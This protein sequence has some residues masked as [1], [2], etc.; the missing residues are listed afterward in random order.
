MVW[1]LGCTYLSSALPWSQAAD[2]ECGPV[3]QVV[4][5]KACAAKP[6]G[7]IWVPGGE[8]TMGTDDPEA[9]PAERP[10]HRVRVT[11]FWMDVT[12]ITNAKY[13]RFV[14]ATNYVTVAQRPLDSEELKKQVPPGTPKPAD[15]LLKP[16]SLV[17]TPPDRP[18]PFDNSAM[19]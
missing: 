11:G 12:E 16:G 7:M 19:W 6:P 10:A 15:E 8:F 17:F 1:L 3:A 2:P 9:W 4:N 5:S 13:A 14:E 18:V